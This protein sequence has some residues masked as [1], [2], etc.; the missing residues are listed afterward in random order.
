[1][2][3]AYEAC[4]VVQEDAMDSSLPAK[5]GCC[6]I[7]C[8]EFHSTAVLYGVSFNLSDMERGA[9][10]HDRCVCLLLADYVH[11]IGAFKPSLRGAMYRLCTLAEGFGNFFERSV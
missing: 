11:G 2:A 7:G 9:F 6:V 1:M 4:W 10:C 5:W 3:Q 8:R